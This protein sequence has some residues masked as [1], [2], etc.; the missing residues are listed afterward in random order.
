MSGYKSTRVT[1]S[2][3]VSLACRA[4]KKKEY[5]LFFSFFFH[6]FA[7]YFCKNLRETDRGRYFAASGVQL[8]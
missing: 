1:F 2:C 3:A 5:F 6:V 7:F 8:A 4:K